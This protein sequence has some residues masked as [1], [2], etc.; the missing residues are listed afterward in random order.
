[1]NDYEIWELDSHLSN[2]KKNLFSDRERIHYI[3]KELY[4]Q[5]KCSTISLRKYPFQHK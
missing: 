1:M 4:G 2:N 3:K 5:K